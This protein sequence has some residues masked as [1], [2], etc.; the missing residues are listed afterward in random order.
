AVAAAAVREGAARLAVLRLALLVGVAGLAR[1]ARVLVRG[2]RR[3]VLAGPL[4][5]GDVA[6]PARPRARGGRA[7]HAVAAVARLA[8][9]PRRGR[10]GG[11]VRARHAVG[12]VLPDLLRAVGG[13]GRDV[14][15]EDDGGPLLLV[16][17]HEVVLAR[18]RLDAARGGLRPGAGG[19]V[20]LPRVV[21]RRV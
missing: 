17:D 1:R 20:P 6:G 5:A 9:G 3:H 8:G 16:E 10:A 18:Q 19:A 4:L 7:A 15:A 13:V 11:P 12:D 14:A 2:A 21:R